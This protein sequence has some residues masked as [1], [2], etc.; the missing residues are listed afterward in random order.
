MSGVQSLS[1]GLRPIPGYRL[2]VLLGRGGYGEVWQ[3]EVEDGRNVALKFMACDDRL[4]AAKEIR[5]IQTIRQLQHPGL[6]RID[7]VWA[8]SG[9]LVVAMELAE[10]S[11][12]DLL[13]AYQDE[14]GTA[15]GQEEVRLYLS[16]IA[17][18]LDFLNQR[19]HH[20]DGNLVAFQHCDVKPGNMLLFGETIKLCDFGLSSQSS[21]RLQAHRKAGTLDYAAPEIF[22]GNLSAQSDQYALA[23]SYCEL[24]SGRIPFPKVN[25]F[26]ASWPRE[27][28]EADL[29]MLTPP[30]QP[31][32]ARALERVPMSRWSS[33]AEMMAEL[34][35]VVG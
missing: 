24:R 2:R 33:C 31:I 8:T 32:I 17:D 9:Y 30:E 15:I 11:L 12:A 3:A 19:Q 5:A 23:I 1:P 25:S 13:A 6:V 28:P 21:A 29:S 4:A 16:Q 7:Q 18:T 26:R 34:T 27:R 35:K 14:F 20:V 22:E 10:G